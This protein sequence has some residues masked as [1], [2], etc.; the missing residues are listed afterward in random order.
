V[1]AIRA[2]I[3]AAPSKIRFTLPHLSAHDQQVIDDVLRDVLTE[4]ADNPPPP[5]EDAE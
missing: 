2:G 1:R 5:D 3:L 4:I